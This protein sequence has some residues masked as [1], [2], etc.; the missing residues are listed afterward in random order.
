M[1]FAEEINSAADLPPKVVYKTSASSI[2]AG[3]TG[4]IGSVFVSLVNKTSSD[5][6]SIQKMKAERYMKAILDF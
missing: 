4:T 6:T 3:I 2:K 5:R 1:I